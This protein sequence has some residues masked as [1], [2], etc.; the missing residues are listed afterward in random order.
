MQAGTSK[1]EAGKAVRDLKNGRT[2]AGESRSRDFESP[3]LASIP[4]IFLAVTKLPQDRPGNIDLSEA[5]EICF[6]VS[7]LRPTEKPK[8][9]EDIEATDE[10]NESRLN[11]LLLSIEM[12]W[13]DM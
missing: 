13:D 5:G 7:L 10:S 4:L 2:E 8:T 6:H 3:Q 1:T 9:T 12:V 11:E